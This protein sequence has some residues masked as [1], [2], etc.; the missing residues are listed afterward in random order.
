M[1]VNKKIL[2]TVLAVLVIGIVIILAT[3]LKKD[4]MSLKGDYKVRMI[5]NILKNQ[6]FP[7]VMGYS[8]VVI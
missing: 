3:T 2:F 1:E 7:N 6:R 4:S 5:K 8:T